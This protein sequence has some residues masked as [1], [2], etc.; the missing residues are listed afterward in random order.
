MSYRS[1]ADPYNLLGQTETPQHF[2][3]DPF[4]LLGQKESFPIAVHLTGTGEPKL[5][6]EWNSFHQNFLSGIPVFFRWARIPKDAPAID[7][8]RDCRIQRRMPYRAVLAAALWHIV[9]FMVPWPHF[10]VRAQHNS[11]LDNTE[12]SWSGPIDDLP[13]LN[14]PKPAHKSAAPNRV[15][16]DPPAPGVDAYHP[17]QRIFTDPVHP[18]HPRQTLVN[19]A[20]PPDSPKFL[21]PLPNMVQLAASAGPARPRLQ[22]SEAALAKLKPKTVKHTATTDMP[23]PD[24]P[25]VELQPADLSLAQATNA[26]ARP[27][28]DINAG[29]TP[30]LAQ[31][32]QKGESVSA[33]E[34]ANGATGAT[35]GPSATIIALSGNPAPPAPVVEVPKGNL[36]ARVSISPEGKG[37]G[38]G[39]GSGNA[40]GTGGGSNPSGGNGIGNNSVGISISGGSPPPKSGISGLGGGSKLIIPKPEGAYKRPDASIASEEISERVGPPNFAVLPPGAPPE[41]V[42]SSHRVY[43]LNVNMPNLNSSTGSWIIRFSELHLSSGAHR[44]DDVSMPTPLHKVDPKYPPDLLKE[45]VQGEVVL[46]GVIREDGSVDSIQLVRGVD[47]QLNA[48]SIAAFGQWKFRPAM[49]DGQPIALE[50]IVHIPFR[51]PPRE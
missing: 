4:N 24:V 36:S 47:P 7:V 51:E 20:A 23:T 3:V 46:Y 27:K 45:H 37:N 19:T 29:S 8:F 16:P 50:A 35:G 31:Q 10:P 40:G 14:I 11:G 22:I 33:P 15:Q 39:G 38:S 2:R 44:N 5:S 32:S 25:N 43:S 28:L 18:T 13:L 21:T 1:Q 49:K 34:L 30:R 42:F 6:I 17:R 48:N 26:P 41:Q 9:F 12:L